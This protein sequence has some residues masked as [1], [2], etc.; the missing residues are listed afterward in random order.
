MGKMSVYDIHGIRVTSLAC[1]MH[2]VHDTDD[3]VDTAQLFLLGPLCMCMY[4]RGADAAS[5]SIVHRQ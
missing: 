3:S 2:A 4:D 5:H 1:D